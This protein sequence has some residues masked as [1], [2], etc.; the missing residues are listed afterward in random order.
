VAVFTAAAVLA[1]AVLV[2]G[3]A[4][5]GVATGDPLCYPASLRALWPVRHEISQAPMTWT[6]LL[7]LPAVGWTAQAALRASGLCRPPAGHAQARNSLSSNRTILDAL[8]AER[9]TRS[10]ESEEP[11]EDAEIDAFFRADGAPGCGAAAPST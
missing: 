5:A 11:L 1:P 6:A 8:L 9:A 10:R 2:A 7:C 3:T 4:V